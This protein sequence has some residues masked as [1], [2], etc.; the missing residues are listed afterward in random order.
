MRD[1]NGFIYFVNVVE[2]GGF[3]QASKHLGMP[4]STLSRRVTDLESQ[5]GVQLLQRSTRRVALTA[6]GDALYERCKP[7]VELAESAQEWASTVTK[8]P[9]G[10]L[11]VSCPITLSQ[12][13]LTPIIPGFLEQYPRI[14]LKLAVTNRHVDLIEQKVDIAVRV[15]QLPL[16]DSQ[17]ITRRMGQA[18][19]IVVASNKFLERQAL[20]VDPMEITRFPTLSMPRSG[21][22]HSWNLTDGQRLLEVMHQPRLVTG[23]MYSLREA[24]LQ[25]SGLALLPQ[26]LCKDQLAS[27]QLRRV[28][29]DWRSPTSEIYI[30]FT[31]RKGMAPS[32]RAFIEFLER[33]RDRL[34]P[35]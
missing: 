32:V 6:A 10:D 20:P 28:L 2:H 7:M 9:E 27:G 3:T 25:G 30:A 11:R 12:M 26:V 8:V 17:Q 22:R 13:W 15:R 34:E 21:D 5:L 18:N 14:N 23:D 24:A 35:A 4:K 33:H 31:S 29:N 1:L 19:D 16:P